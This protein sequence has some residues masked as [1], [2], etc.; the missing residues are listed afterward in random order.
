VFKSP[1]G[2]L[3]LFIC[4]R[5]KI[6][7]Y[8]VAVVGSTGAVGQQM[9]KFLEKRHFPVRKL[10]PLASAKSAGKMVSF[11]GE[12]IPVLE[13]TPDAFHGVD[14]ALFSA[15]GGVSKLLAPE[16][17]KRGAVVI[18]NSSAYRMEPD[19][20]LIV[21]EVNR[22]ALA[23]HQGIIANPNCSTIQMV[24]ALKPLYDHFGI[25]RIIVSTYQAVSGAGANAIEELRSQSAAMLA[26]VEPVAN[27][28]PVGKLDQYYP[29][30]FNVIPQIDVGMDNGFTFEEMKMVQETKKIMGD[31]TIG[32]TPTCVR[33]PVYRGHSEAVYVEL[34]EDYQLSDVRSLLA[35]SPGIIVQDEIKEQVYPM[36]LNSEDFEEVFIG[37]LR[38]DLTHPRGLNMWVVSD[39]LLKGAA[40]NAVQIAE[41]LVED[42]MIRRG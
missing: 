15:G 38:R 10:V 24:V 13:A 27:V 3:P 30:A 20:P 29:I 31:E 6:V 18:D 34:K 22:E 40:T 21:P 14:I 41:A 8:T 33:V 9:I 25:D 16:A 23:E 17:V 1:L 28:L 7:T 37:R 12:A 4:R 36:P 26:G 2:D 19:V 35:D 42:Q 39:N 11:H 5:R 32:I